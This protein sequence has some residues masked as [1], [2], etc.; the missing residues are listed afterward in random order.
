MMGHR[1]SPGVQHRRDCDPR[2][3]VFGIGRDRQ[4]RLGG[5]PEQQIVDHRLV[6]IGDIADRRRQGEHDMEVRHGQKLRCPRRALFDMAS[7]GV[8]G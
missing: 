4:H 5:R 3:Q 7:S 1:T 6:L 8:T 2:P